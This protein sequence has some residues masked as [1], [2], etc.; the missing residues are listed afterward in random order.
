LIYL[1]LIL[2][3][4]LE[5]IFSGRLSLTT[6]DLSNFDTN[7]D[8]NMAVIFKECSSLTNIDLSNFNTN[9]ATNMYGMFYGC[10]SL[11][12]NNIII[13]DE[14]IYNNEDTFKKV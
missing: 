8:T 11:N 9:N 14:R 13:K 7:N 2:L 10:S 12:R 1:I 5:W 3:T 6:I 4:L